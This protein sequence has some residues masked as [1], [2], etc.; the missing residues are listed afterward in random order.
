MIVKPTATFTQEEKLKIDQFVMRGGKLLMFID[1]LNAE[2]DSLQ[3]KNEVI[4]Y[5]RNLQLD[6]LLFKYGVRI[7]NDLVLDIQ[8]DRLPFDVNGNGQ[9]DFLKWNYFP[10]FISRSNHTI[11]KNIGFVSG[12]FVNSIDTVGAEEIRKTTIISTSDNGKKIATPALISGRE[13][14][15]APNDSSFNVPNIPVA[16]LLEGKFNSMFSNRLSQNLNDSLSAYGAT[17]MQQCIYDNKMIVV[18]DGDMVLNSVHKE[19]PMPMGYNP[20][21]VGSQYEMQFANRD[22]LQNCLDYLVDPTGLTEAR[23]KDYVLRL[24]DKKKT[25][26]DRN[27][28]QVINIAVPVLL[29]CLF[30]FIYQFIR[31]KKYTIELRNNG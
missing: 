29:I 24:L 17:Y 1:K 30:A 28:W 7:N 2:M 22:L 26:R 19:S 9:F 6:D 12:R 3:I 11:N 15:I 13:N 25:D 21:T 27:F 20:F 18:A 31:R 10:V 23:S 4:A 14:Q 5:D 16:M 8:S